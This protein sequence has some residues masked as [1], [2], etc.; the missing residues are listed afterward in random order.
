MLQ[1]SGR[2]NVYLGPHLCFRLQD[3]QEGRLLDPHPP[4]VGHSTP[5]WHAGH[6]IGLWCLSVARFVLC[7]KWLCC[8]TSFSNHPLWGVFVWT[9]GT[10]LTLQCQSF[11]ASHY[12][13]VFGIRTMRALAGCLVLLIHST[14]LNAT[15][16]LLHYSYKHSAKHTSDWSKQMGKWQQ[17]KQ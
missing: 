10:S 13:D 4:V 1:T 6:E 17:W 16:F 7:R 2:W 15:S 3:R 8:Q 12:D 5:L 11:I 14:L 9:E